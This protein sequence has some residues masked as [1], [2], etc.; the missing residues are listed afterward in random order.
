MDSRV[1]V[2][3]FASL[4]S[5][6]IAGHVYLRREREAVHRSF[7]AFASGVA[8]LEAIS[9]LEALV[10]NP[11]W[12]R[13]RSFATV[14]V[15][16]LAMRFFRAF[17]REDAP[18]AR[19]LGRVARL[20]SLA[21][22]GMLATPI[23]AHLL[24]RFSVVGFVLFSFYATLATLHRSRIGTRSRREA[25]RIRFLTL[26]GGVAGTL[27]L[28]DYLPTIGELDVG[29]IAPVFLVG[30]LYMLSQAVVR[31]RIL[32]LYDLAGRA[33]VLTTVA[34]VLAA[35][36]MVMSRITGTRSFAHAFVSAL[37]VLLLLDPLRTAVERWIHRLLFTDRH[38]FEVALQTVRERI[39]GAIEPANVAQIVATALEDSGR[40]THAGIWFVESDRRGFAL[41]AHVG[42]PPPLRLE[43]IAIRAVLDRLAREPALILETVE[44]ELD[45]KR[46]HGDDRDAET[47][48]EV[49]QCM[50]AMHASVVLAIVADRAE[51][52]GL[53]AIRDERIR[54]AYAAEEV[55]LIVGL[56]ASVGAAFSRSV[57]YRSAKERDRLIAL[58]EMAAGLAHEIRNP[59]GAI[60]ATA[61]LLGDPNTTASERE[62]LDII[63]EEADRLNR[64]VGAF[65]DYARPSTHDETSCD[66]VSTIE[67]T[68]RLL[69]AEPL[70][71]GPSL[72]LDV[73]N[74]VPAVSMDAEKL[75]QVVWNLARNALEALE[76]AGEL[77]IHV[78][79]SAPLVGEPTTGDWV[80]ITV[81]D[82]GPGIPD[83]VLPHLFV[84]FVTTKT[85]GTGLGLAMSQR[86]IT[87]AGGRIDVRSQAGRGA[88]FVVRLPAVRHSESG[89]D[90][91]TGTT[92]TR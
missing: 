74:N 43:P 44:R 85:R 89:A 77:R 2:A 15:A 60:R 50:E 19:G 69:E 83:S 13:A 6:A 51:T 5:M 47:I 80:E 59:L 92:L 79:T 3:T 36:L 68:V 46:R 12:E 18:V 78:A 91:E 65:L 14:G 1:Q 49:V 70:A 87:S 42:P 66:P 76:G 31:D 16:L 39:A 58:G 22:F 27:T 10:A 35:T 84:P 64:V 73:E 21:V 45:R 32:D 28:A 88:V 26:T 86:L 72:V 11:E 33:G 90:T 7:A 24:A 52:V 41:A 4:L 57:L 38:R 54:D 8:V 34:L 82:T 17:V 75:R 25:E 9:V 30:F 20:A 62:F 48:Y 29:A 40:V 81:S 67:R 63:V 55:Q 23:F 53:I 61:Q 37:V 71:R 56:S